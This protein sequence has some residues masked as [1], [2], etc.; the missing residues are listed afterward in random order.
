[1]E[2]NS[3]LFRSSSNFHLMTEPKLKAD[4]EAGNLSKGARTHCIDIFASWFYKR[5]EEIYSKYMEK[6]TAVEEQAITLLSLITRNVYFKNE[7]NITNEYISGTPDLFL[8]E[9][10]VIK[11]VEDIKSSWDI[12]TFLRSKHNELQDNYYWQMQSYMWLT[13]A[14]EAN[15]RYCLVNSLPEHIDDEKRKTSWKMN[16]IDADNDPKYVERC[17][18]I[19][20]N[21]IY[22]IAD[23]QSRY[24]YY[25]FHNNLSEW[26][27]DIPMEQRLHTFNIKRNQEDI[28]LLMSKV[29]KARLFIQTLLPNEQTELL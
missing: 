11:V 14:E 25:S 13:G 6:G 27:Y 5:R 7:E 12:F 16:L 15:I 19:E 8:K 20:R 26:V 22:D 29:I 1:M 4:K 2:V 28:D 23:F 10:G 21:M 3:I 18:M 24:P 17:K 9:N